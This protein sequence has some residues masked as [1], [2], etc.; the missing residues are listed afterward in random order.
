MSQVSDAV[1]QAWALWFAISS[2]AVSVVGFFLGRR[3]LDRIG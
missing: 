3:W 2:L 1:S